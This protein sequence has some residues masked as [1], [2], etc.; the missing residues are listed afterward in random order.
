MGVKWKGKKIVAGLLVLLLLSSIVPMP[1]NAASADDLKYTISNGEVTITDCN[2]TAS[3]E[4]VIPEIIE[5]YPVTK[6]GSFAF[7]DCNNLTGIHIPPKVKKIELWAFDCDNLKDIYITDLAAWCQIDCESMLAAPMEHAKNLYLN[8]KRLEGELVIPAGVTKISTG[9]FENCDGLTNIIIP[10]S[11]KKIEDYAFCNCTAITS[12]NI[13]SNVKEIGVLAFI[14]CHN[15]TKIYIESLNSWCKINFAGEYSNPLNGGKASLYINKEKL[16]GVLD[17]PAGI[18]NIKDYTFFNYKDITNINLPSELQRIGNSAFENCGSLTRVVIPD[19]VTTIGNE[20]FRACYKL[21]DVNIPQKVISIGEYAFGWCKMTAVDIPKGCTTIGKNAFYGCSQL[22]YVTIPASAT[23][24]GKDVFENCNPNLILYANSKYAYEYAIANNIQCVLKLTS[25]SIEQLPN[26]TSYCLNENLNINGLALRASLG[27]GSSTIIT[28]GFELSGFDSTKAGTCRVNVKYGELETFFDVNV[29]ATHSYDDDG[30]SSCNICEHERLIESLKIKSLPKKTI[31]GINES[32]DSSDLILQLNYSDGTS[33]EISTGFVVSGFDSTKAGTCTITAEYIGV[34]T[35]FD[36]SVKVIPVT[37]IKLGT[38]NIQIAI[39]DT[40]QSEVIYT[41]SNATYK[42]VSWKSLDS[43][44]ATVDSNGVITAVAV[45]TTKIQATSENGLTAECVVTVNNCKSISTSAEWFAIKNN[46]SGMTYK[47]MAD[48]SVGSTLLTIPAQKEVVIDLNGHTVRGTGSVIKN[49]GNL[50]ITDSSIGGMICLNTESIDI[51]CDL[52]ENRGTMKLTGGKLQMIS[53]SDNKYFSTVIFNCIN[54]YG[55]L[56]IEDGEIY[57]NTWMESNSAGNSVRGIYNCS[58]GSLTMTGGKIHVETTTETYITSANKALGY[59]Y[60]IY[61]ESVKD[62]NISGATIIC[63]VCFDSYGSTNTLLV[64]ALLNYVAADVSLK[65]TI[66]EVEV[67][68]SA[69]ALS[70]GIGG[71]YNLSNG[72]IKVDRSKINVKADFSRSKDDI[73]ADGINN[74]STGSVIIGSLPDSTPDNMQIITSHSNH[75]DSAVDNVDTGSVKIQR[76]YLKGSIGVFNS[77]NGRMELGINDGMVD[78]NMLSISGTESLFLSASQIYIYDGTFTGNLDSASPI[79]IPDGYSL[80]KTDDNGIDK[81]VLIGK[82]LINININKKELQI[83]EGKKSTLTVVYFPFDTTDEKTVKWSSSNE[84]IVIVD[85]NGNITALKPGI[86]TI[87]ATVGSFTATCK[88]TV[89]ADNWI[90]DSVGWW[91]RN[92]DGSYPY[93]CWKLIENNWY[94]FNASGY[95]VTGWQTIGGT[96]YYF[97]SSGAMVTGWQTISGTRYYFNGSG[98]MMI[99]WQLIGGTWY[100]LNGSGAMLTGWQAIGGTWYYFNG[101]GA[102]VA[103]QWV[104]N[105]YLQADG[106]MATNQWV[107]NYYVQNDG[108]YVSGAGWL[109]VGSDW[110]YLGAGGVKQTSQWINN[111]YVKAN[112]VM[113]TNEWIGIYWV[114][115]NGQWIPNYRPQNVYV[116]Q[117]KNYITNYGDTNVYGDKFISISTTE[118]NTTHTFAIVYERASDGIEFLVVSEN[119]DWTISMDMSSRDYSNCKVTANLIATS[120]WDFCEAMG[121]LDTSTYTENSNVYFSLISSSGLPESE[122]Q[123]LGNV[124]LQ[125]GFKVWSSMVEEATGIT[126]NQ[127]GFSSYQ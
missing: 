17:I 4:L 79:K 69:K 70:G 41:P 23:S 47:L 124:Y 101:S 126:M 98:A 49:N 35:T 76:G 18:T 106:S 110:Y 57:V 64:E 122:I 46:P 85:S 75:K 118:Q 2:E 87:T 95:R 84:S 7:S 111:Y 108:A 97:N 115:S 3:G 1:A 55:T 94:Y 72:T 103:N 78:S 11:V 34:K 53:N 28:N 36:V 44:V 96:W 73:P 33:K 12:V 74:S 100:Y 30:D 51:T 121:T 63:L 27:D 39:G 105:Y 82:P 54:N 93:S 24:I 29:N 67:Y 59:M 22:N 21:A 60:G 61:N 32:F 37:E 40:Y 83:T 81:Y 26:K 113:A 15:I 38:Q 120:D 16:N 88:V 114:G 71:I 14:G 9:A 77:D 42:E 104:G 107:G 10:D 25:L 43:S 6:I 20:A 5:G 117:L 123:N 127:L 52:I 68:A 65:D 89:V 48:I 119:S 90:K 62:L 56:E 8:G 86:A 125:S 31:Y 92:A 66:I 109:P 50:T 45:G 102:M 112:G 99:G 80:S 19:G 116:Q 13:P 91:Y 58:G